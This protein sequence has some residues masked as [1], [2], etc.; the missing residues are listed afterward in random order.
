M[1]EGCDKEAILVALLAIADRL[2]DVTEVLA[3]ATQSNSH[4]GRP[5]GPSE[6]VADER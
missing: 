2:A 1:A 4:D 6:K 5:L 3:A